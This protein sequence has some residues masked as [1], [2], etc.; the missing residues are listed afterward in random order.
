M[1]KQSYL[2]P[3][4]KHPF[5]MAYLV[6]VVFAGM[7]Q[8]IHVLILGLVVEAAAMWLL[9]DLPS[10]QRG[11]ESAL[12]VERIERQRWY[13]LRTLW[14]VEEPRSSNPFVSTT[15]EWSRLFSKWA[16]GEQGTF[17]RLCRIVEELQGYQ[18]A[19]P[20]S[21][22][23]DLILRMDEMIN[24]WLGLLYLISNTNSSITLID[25]ASLAKEFAKLK[26]QADKAD[27]NDKATRIVLGERLRTIKAKT[28]NLPKLERRK[29]LAQAQADTIVAQIEAL[30]TQVRTAG[31]VEA[32][33][34]LDTSAMLD[35]GVFQ[36]GPDEVEL[37]AEI[38]SLTSGSDLDL[39]NKA[40]WDDIGSK[41][42]TDK[43]AL[44]HEEPVLPPLPT[45]PSART[46]SRR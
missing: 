42:G 34:L 19:H 9:P 13:Y 22:T 36:S 41:L 1:A 46:R 44:T 18:E 14:S 29:A 31:A 20:E 21:V 38:R 37:A 27:P 7:S 10:V 5:N 45:I 12:R 40:V 17:I 4:F 15:V 8:G 39:D 28:D 30:S 23:D 16:E 35:G 26:E 11:I 32:G 2:W 6:G 24:A 33:T 3:V 25:Q 43:P